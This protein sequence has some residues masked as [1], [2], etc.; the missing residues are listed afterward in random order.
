MQLKLEQLKAALVPSPTRCL[1]EIHKL[2]PQLAER[3]YSVFIS[4]VHEYTTRLGTTPTSP[5]EFVAHLQLLQQ[6]EREHKAMDR[7]FDKV[8]QGNFCH[9]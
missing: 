4:Q 9:L 5:E 2:L 3:A 7:E 8:R 6:V 1:S